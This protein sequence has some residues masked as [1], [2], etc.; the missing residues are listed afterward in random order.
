MCGALLSHTANTDPIMAVDVK[1]TFERSKDGPAVVRAE[2]IDRLSRRASGRLSCGVLLLGSAN[3]S[4]AAR[5]ALE[6]APAGLLA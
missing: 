4:E 2:T 6:R 5:Q 3:T 1:A